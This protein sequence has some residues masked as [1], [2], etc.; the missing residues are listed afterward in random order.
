MMRVYRLFAVTTAVVPDDTGADVYVARIATAG[1]IARATLGASVRVLLGATDGVN[2][3]AVAVV[4]ISVIDV[5]DAAPVYT[6]PPAAHRSLEC[7]DNVT[8]CMLRRGATVSEDVS[9]D[10]V[11]YAFSASDADFGLNGHVVFTV[12]ASP[13]YGIPCGSSA[14]LF[15]VADRG[16]VDGVPGSFAGVLTVHPDRTLDFETQSEYLVCV[17]ASDLGTPPRHV[18]CISIRLHCVLVVSLG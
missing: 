14:G 15:S 18:L 9:S 7:L 6:L 13:G 11:L 1:P 12:T 8:A 10:V 16:S 17:L 2:G 5:N 4:A 3:Q